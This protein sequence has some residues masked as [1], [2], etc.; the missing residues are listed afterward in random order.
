ML[1]TTEA[2][3]TLSRRVAWKLVFLPIVGLGCLMS[4]AARGAPWA[5]LSADQLGFLAAWLVP[6]ACGLGLL[7]RPRALMA[8]TGSLA[9]L[10]LVGVVL[11]PPLV[12]DFSGLRLL[13]LVLLG[14]APAVALVE[15]IQL[16]RA[17]RRR[18]MLEL[19]AG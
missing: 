1:T 9:A 17:W 7:A 16:D 8:L 4:L 11:V 12:A 5:R 6:L 15:S 14:A 2:L 18:A 10:T 3:P 19:L 13:D